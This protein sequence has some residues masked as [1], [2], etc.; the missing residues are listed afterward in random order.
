MFSKTLS[1]KI[2]LLIYR[3]IFYVTFVLLTAGLDGNSQLN[4]D[5]TISS[6]EGCS[7]LVVAFTN[8]TTGASANATWEWDFDNG[9]T[10][11]LKSP[12]AIFLDEMTYT[13]TL[14]VNDGSQQSVKTKT[15]TVYKKPVIDFTVN[16][17]NGCLPLNIDFN[18]SASAGDGTVTA[19]YWDF[20]DGHTQQTTS[21]YVNHLYTFKQTA[22]VSLTAVNNYGCSN[23]LLKDSLIA[24]KNSVTASFSANQTVLCGPSETVS[25]TNTSTGPAPLAYI[26]DFGD[27]TNSSTPTPSHTYTAPGAYSVT[28]AVTSAEGCTVS[29]TEQNYINVANFVSDFEVPSIICRGKMIQFKNTSSPRPSQSTW[30]VNGLLVATPDTVLNY[31]FPSAGFYDIRLV[32]NF[33]TCQQEITKQVEIKETPRLDTFIVQYGSFCNSPFPVSFT[34]TSSEAVKWRWNFNYFSGSTTVMSTAQGITYTYIYEGDYNVHLEIENAIGCSSSISNWVHIEKNR[35]YIKE[36]DSAG[37]QRCDSIT[38]KYKAI[39]ANS[40]ITGDSITVYFWDFGDGSTSA[41]STPVHTYKIRGEYY[42]KLTYTTAKGCTAT[43]QGPQVLVFNPPVA[44]FSIVPEVC[45]NNYVFVNSLATGDGIWLGWDWGDNTGLG[46]YNDR[47][48]YQQEGVYSITM[49]AS[50][51]TCSDTIT[52]N[53]IIKVKGPFLRINGIEYTCDGNRDVI[54]IID[55]TTACDKWIWDFGD[56]TTTTYNNFQ[57][58]LTHQYPNSWNYPVKLTA[59]KDA[60]VLQESVDV[61]I[62]KKQNPVLTLDNEVCCINTGIPFHIRNLESNLYI[63]DDFNPRYSSE[64]WEYFSG[65]PFTGTWS[66]NSWTWY[67]DLDGN[68]LPGEVREDSIRMI[69]KSYFHNCLDTTNYVAIKVKGVNADFDVV[70]DNVCF[71]SPVILNNLSSATTGNAIASYTWNFGDGQQLTTTQGGIV[72]HIYNSPGLYNVTLDVADISGCTS[73]ITNAS[74]PVRV[75]GVKAAFSVSPSATVTENTPI[76]FINNSNTAFATGVVSWEWDFGDGTISSAMNPTNTYPTEGIYIVKLIATDQGSACKDTA[77]VTITVSHVLPNNVFTSSSVFIGN[78]G[79]CLPVNVGFSYSSNISFTK[80]VWDFG[81]GVSLEDQPAPSH[82]YTLPGNYIVS[83]GVYN[84]AQLIGTY[85][86]TIVVTTPQAAIAATDLSLCIGDNMELFSPLKNTGYN[87]TWDFGNGHVTNSSDSIATGTYNWAGSFAP[88]LII[89]DARG[90]ATSVKLADQIVVHPDPVITVS[91]TVA[92]VCKDNGVQLEASGAQHYTWSPATGLSDVSISNPVASPAITTDYN[93]Q[94]VDANGCKGSAAVKVTVLQPFAMQTI[95]AVD[96][97]EGESVQLS[98]SGA[99]NYSWINHTTGLS[100]TAIANPF[101]NPAQTT[102]YTVVGFDPYGCYSDTADIVVTIRSSPTVSLGNDLDLAIGTPQVL[103]SIGSNDV[104][105]WEWTPADYLSCTNCPA[106][107]S[108]PLSSVEYLLKVFNQYNCEASDSIKITTF[109][110]GG[111][112]DVPNAFTPNGDGK[113]DV[114]GIPAGGISRVRN[115]RIYNRWGEL[116]FQKKDFV[117][118]DITGSWNGKYKGLDAP[119]ATYVYM[120]EVECG[121]GLR[122]DLKGTVTLIR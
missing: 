120:A 59:E 50:N 48:Q 12:S 19:W 93:V 81:D 53:N 61:Y 33:G 45:G 87:Y 57:P 23:T 72:T 44:D 104:V 4:A 43:I 46:Y 69:T 5:F 63:L 77:I 41:D 115:L 79:S 82:I 67:E 40:A 121:A 110:K 29:K 92:L 108:T 99:A 6:N 83:L 3:R 101:A 119:T 100:N 58:S 95:S 107:V 76:S 24:V 39:L 68:L 80:L 30:Y 91:P 28:L 10:S 17:T 14:K 118:G 21:A 47:H 78:N 36:L 114:F 111:N 1:L 64:K 116:V 38:K 11:S 75:N 86:D 2:S 62:L 74:N 96:I 16:V 102:T 35:V 15:V 52:K 109:C 117:P 88:S 8:T 94:A 113:N 89:T 37:F 65:D 85:L 22:S 13:V 71:K 105:R 32:N 122:F 56:G 90:C 49:V 25:F 66:N 54:K 20:G 26:W 73:S 103:Q 60:C 70:T 9:N 97:C 18:A 98:V 7:P 42:P 55:S 106:P 112:I 27:G 51:G 84:G 34:D 31:Q